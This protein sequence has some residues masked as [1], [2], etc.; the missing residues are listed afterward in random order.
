MRTRTRTG[1]FRELNAAMQADCLRRPSPLAIPDSVLCCCALDASPRGQHDDCPLAPTDSTSPP[2]PHR[3]AESQ[4]DLR[5]TTPHFM[6]P[7]SHPDPS[8]AYEHIR[9][10]TLSLPNSPS[11]TI[12]TILL[13]LL[14]LAN[15]V[16]Y[17]RLSRSSKR[18][19]VLVARALQALQALFTTVLATLLFSNVVPS[20][21]RTC[22]LSTI[23]QR[24]FRHHDADAIRRIQDEFHC[25][26][27][28][29]VRDRAWPF[30][31][32][33]S[34]GRC[35]DMYGREVS[36]AQP[37]L[38]ALQRNSGFDFGIVVAVGLFQIATWLLSESTRFRDESRPRPRGMI[39]YGTTDGPEGARLLPGVVGEEDEAA[40]DGSRSRS[41]RTTEEQAEQNGREESNGVRVQGSSTQENPWQ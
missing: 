30:P 17:L 13:P 25:C 11:L 39:H 34:A 19:H 27:F 4:T 28:N 23:W 3:V 5:F 8:A 35:A 20:A 29:T 1:L 37:W 12:P 15:A 33:K 32:H 38:A 6:F 22:L 36:C 16:A 9:S 24:L 31:D 7:V 18:H 10:A 14:A 2:R 40:E 41:E 21:V 26:G